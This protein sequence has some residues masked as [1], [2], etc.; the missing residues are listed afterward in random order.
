MR[1]LLATT[2]RPVQWAR[3]SNQQARRNAMVS[4][5]ELAAR[6]HERTEVEAYVAAVV[7]GREHARGGGSSSSEHGH[8]GVG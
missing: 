7:A 4:S 2:L 8:R 1:Q 5:T 6:R 3:E